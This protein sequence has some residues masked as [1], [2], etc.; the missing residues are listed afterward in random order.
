[1]RIDWILSTGAALGVI[2]AGWIALF[3]S[4][5]LAM[6]SGTNTA[7]AVP[8]AVAGT[9]ALVGLLVGSLGLL[10]ARA[11]IGQTASVLLVAVSAVLG[12]V[13]FVFAFSLHW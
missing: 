13:A 2:A 11:W 8:L 7:I 1:M 12:L 6:G 3:L 4:A 9:A 10:R 5:G